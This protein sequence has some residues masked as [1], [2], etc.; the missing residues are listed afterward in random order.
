MLVRNGMTNKIINHSRFS[1]SLRCFFY[2]KLSSKA[3]SVY[4]EVNEWEKNRMVRLQQKAFA[5]KTTKRK[6]H[7]C[8]SL[9]WI[10][11]MT[12]SSLSPSLYTLFIL[13]I[14]PH[15]L[16]ALIAPI[17]LFINDGIGNQNNDSNDRTHHQWVQKLFCQ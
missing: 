8:S 1:T 14:F 17:T 13:F 2:L 15:F 11:V 3:I 7:L 10:H 4:H 5:D 9:K 12:F 16:M 6:L